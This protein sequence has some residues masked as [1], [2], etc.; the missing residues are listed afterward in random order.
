MNWERLKNYPEYRDTA[1]AAASMISRF[2]IL[3]LEFSVTAA[4]MA[5]TAA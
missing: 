1:A 5:S 2:H 3:Q 4:G